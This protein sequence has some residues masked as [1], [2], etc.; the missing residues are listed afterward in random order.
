VSKKTIGTDG[1][2]II[3]DKKLNIDLTITDEET[4]NKFREYLISY[5]LNRSEDLYQKSKN[6]MYA[7]QLIE[8]CE[9]SKIDYPNWV[10]EYLASCASNLLNLHYGIGEDITKSVSNAIGMLKKGGGASWIM[11]QKKE[12]ERMSAI[13]DLERQRYNF[14]GKKVNIRRDEQLAKIESLPYSIDVKKIHK[15]Q[16]NKCFRAKTMDQIFNDVA[17]IY[18]KSPR[19][20]RDWWYG[21]NK[22]K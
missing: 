10:K 20:I 1:A 12:E 19:T 6:P 3:E 8:F 7:W 14:Y 11:L 4:S 2:D 9:K 13:E 15:Q 16:I 17:K 21:Y 22:Y 18:N 5:Q